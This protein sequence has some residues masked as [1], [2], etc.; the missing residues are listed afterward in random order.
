[1]KRTLFLLP[2][3]VFLAACSHQAPA[4][5]QPAESAKPSA[6]AI[7]HQR[8]ADDAARFMAGIPGN[9][10]SPFREFE[11]DPAWQEHRRVLDDVWSK[12]D[13]SIIQ[14][15]RTFQSKELGGQLDPATVFYPFG[16]PDV[17]TVSL[18]F[19]RTPSYVMVALEP[20]G[21]L[22]TVAQIRKKV[23]RDYLGAVRETVA[24]ELGK[25]FFVTRE[26][27]REFRGQVTD[28]LLT[29]I[30][31]LLVRS[32]HNILGFRY[33]R[34]NEEGKISERAGGVPVNAEHPNKGVE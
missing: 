26:M 21:T 25:S 16:G 15:L 19:P 31:L 2:L 27:D 3:A 13:S 23:L 7:P 32:D 4:Q 24:S 1:M 11:D 10:G 22:P 20:A 28:G 18:F 9:P 6:D 8:D 14:G 17:L 34:L 5:I 29:P 30:L 12:A 33:V